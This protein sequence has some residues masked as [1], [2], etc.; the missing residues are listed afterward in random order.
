MELIALW[1]MFKRR[2]WLMALPAVVA[3]ILTLPSLVNITSPPSTYSVAV[4]LTAAAPPDATLENI[5]TPY[6]DTAYVPLL[7]SEYVVVNMPAWITSDRFAAEV[8]AVLEEQYDLDIPADDLDATF[9]ADSYRSI[10]TLYVSWDEEDEISAIAQAAITVLDER[11]VD[12]FPQFE[13]IPVRVTALDDVEVTEAA[14]PITSRIGPLLRL[15]IG[16]AAGVGLGVLVEYLDPTIYHR[17]DL[18]GLDL[19]LIAEIPRE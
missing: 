6:E 16:L 13:A 17:E 4:R 2:W 9:F 1:H 10:L 12:Y 14:P 8:S 7:A 5:T 19:R 11:N 3:L 18:E 15:F